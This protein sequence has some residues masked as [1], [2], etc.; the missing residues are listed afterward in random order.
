MRRYVLVLF[1]II[2]FAYSLNKGKIKIQEEK[3]GYI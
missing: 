2:T 3:R 1:V